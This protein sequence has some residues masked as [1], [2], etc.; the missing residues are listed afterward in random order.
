MRPGTTR[1]KDE[2]QAA[3]MGER[4]ARLLRWRRLQLGDE[5]GR[6]VWLM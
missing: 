1:P 3:A 6:W 5:L 4:V 2:S